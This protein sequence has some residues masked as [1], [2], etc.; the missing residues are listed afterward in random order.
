MYPEV[1]ESISK[2]LIQ[3]RMKKI[4]GY[5]DIQKYVKE[6]KEGNVKSSSNN[7]K[8]SS[9][10]SIP[11]SEGLTDRRKR[12]QTASE[13]LDID[14]LIKNIEAEINEFKDV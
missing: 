8:A 4:V 6:N 9:C 5:F 14:E 10:R 13:N 7:F 12:P 2:N 3:K 11:T 1:K